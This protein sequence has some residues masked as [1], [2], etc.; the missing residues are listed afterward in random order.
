MLNNFYK[1]FYFFFLF[2]V[3]FF[4]LLL[5]ALYG[6]SLCCETSRL[7]T[8]GFAHGT[9]TAF[10]KY[11]PFKYKFHLNLRALSRTIRWRFLPTKVWASE[12]LLKGQTKKKNTDISMDQTV[13]KKKISLK[14]FY[15]V[16][17]QSIDKWF[18]G[19]VKKT[20]IFCT[21]LQPRDSFIIL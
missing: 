2:F 19:L 15:L 20:K 7:T 12:I 18:I 16:S 8:T 14:L 10:T 6:I 17:V 1:S 3:V 5:G 4:K 21:T 9:H 11:G 13:K